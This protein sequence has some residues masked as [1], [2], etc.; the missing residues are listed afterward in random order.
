VILSAIPN[1]TR[2]DLGESRGPGPGPQ[3]SHHR[4]ASHQTAHILFLANDSADDFFIEFYCNLR[5][6]QCTEIA[7]QEDFASPNMTSGGTSRGD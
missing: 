2:A 4:G 3:A 6:L 1:W 5:V 7:V